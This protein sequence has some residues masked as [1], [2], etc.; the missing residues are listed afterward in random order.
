MGLLDRI[1]R[2]LSEGRLLSAYTAELAQQTGDQAAAGQMARQAIEACKQQAVAEGTDKQ[3]ANYGTMIVSAIRQKHPRTVEIFGPILREGVTLKDIEL[4]WNQSDLERRMVLF[5]EAFS[6]QVVF[7]KA[8]EDGT[9]E[10][11]AARVVKRVFPMYGDPSDGR[12]GSGDDRALPH[13]LSERV[14]AFS[15]ATGAVNIAAA[16]ERYSS[17]NAFVR[18]MMRQGRL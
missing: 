2:P 8:L 15:K 18:E 9:P 10:A 1:L 17:Y 14:E 13:E 7:R 16:V 5:F 11:E 4:W 12:V 6:R 3:P